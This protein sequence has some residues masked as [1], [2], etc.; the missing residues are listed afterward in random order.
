MVIT[1]SRTKYAFLDLLRVIACFLVIVN[2]TNSTIFLSTTPADPNWF[3]S[4]IYFFVSKIAVPL[5]LMISGYLLLSKEDS[6]RKIAQRVARIVIV[7]LAC[8]V[9]YAAYSV[10]FVEHLNSVPAVLKRVATVYFL[11]PTNALWYLYAYIGILITLPFLQKMSARMSR[12]DYHVFFIISGL[13]FSLLPILNHYNAYFTYNGNFFIPLFSSYI[14]M[15]F[16]GQY[17]RKFKIEKTKMAVL[18]ACITFVLMVAFNVVATY[19][20]FY[21][22]TSGYLFFDNITY[23]PIIVASAC[24]FYLV[25]VWEVKQK[26]AKT[27]SYIGSCTFGIYLIS[28]LFIVIETPVFQALS[29]VLHPMIAVILFE[30]LVFASGLALTAVLKKVPLVKKV[31]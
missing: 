3:L 27:V 30:G 12:T 29:G 9:I 23:F 14:C 8:A 24:V 19:H 18:F 4:V 10:F 2:H 16:I 21:N 31:L 15:L 7:L 1:Q 25:S 26:T 6:W 22:S 13:F 5:F 17:F 28:D 11:S 20:E